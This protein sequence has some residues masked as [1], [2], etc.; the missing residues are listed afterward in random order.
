MKLERL[1]RY[2]NQKQTQTVVPIDNIAQIRKARNDGGQESTAL[3]L[4]ILGS[5]LRH[6]SF[7]GKLLNKLKGRKSQ[8]WALMEELKTMIEWE[9]NDLEIFIGRRAARLEAGWRSSR[10][11]TISDEIRYFF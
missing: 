7:S 3:L 2:G 8:R 10:L 6:S 1:E 4:I 9:R 5:H 11:K